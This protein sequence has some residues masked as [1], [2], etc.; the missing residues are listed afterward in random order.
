MKRIVILGAGFGGVA[1]ALEI[2]KNIRSG[3][4]VILINDH[5]YHVLHFALYQVA[6]DEQPSRSVAIPLTT[7][8]A[9]KKVGLK[10]AKVAKI[11]SSENR[12]R[13]ENGDSLS[14]DFLVLALGSETEDNNI[15]GVSEH[16]LPLKTLQDAR[17]IQHQTKDLFARACKDKEWPYPLRIVIGGGGFTGTELAGELHKYCQNLTHRF[18]MD[19]RCFEVAI[20]QSGDQLL[21]GLDKDTARKARERLESLDVKVVLGSHITKLNQNKILLENGREVPFN[22]LIWTVGVRG[23]SLLDASGFKVDKGGRVAVNQN[24]LVKDH[25]NIF[26]CGDN[27]AFPIDSDGHIAP[28]VAPIAIDQGKL[29][30]KNIKNLLEASSQRL[31][32]YHYQHHGYIV[33]ISGRFA[34][35]RLDIISLD[36]YPAFLLQ[37]LNI[38]RYLLSILPPSKAFK[39]WNTFEMELLSDD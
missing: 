11:A 36:G 3:T 34:L 15:S 31:E 27:A 18:M 33:P 21:S 32:T 9:D 30:A 10:I 12:I 25:R 22:L 20:I 14:Y 24:L 16:T 1:C 5:E 39:R 26:A 4:E 8:F 17:K 29:I 37:Q 35:A 28:A 13:F 2:A 19:P 23:N 6:T 7:I 38:L